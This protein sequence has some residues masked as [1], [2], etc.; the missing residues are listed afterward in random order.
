LFNRQGEDI[1]TDYYVGDILYSA[2]HNGG[3]IF[4]IL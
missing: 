4:A 3:C 1:Y 2:V